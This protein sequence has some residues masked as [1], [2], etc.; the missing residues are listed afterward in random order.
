MARVPR[1]T[2][3]VLLNRSNAGNIAAAAAA[4]GGNEARG[5]R[6]EAQQ[7]R[8]TAAQIDS[9]ARQ[10][11]QQLKAEGRV[12]AQERFNQ[13]E[14]KKI[15]L[16]ST[17]QLERQDNPDGFAKEFDQW[18][19]DQLAEF[20]TSLGND[21]VDEA[22]DLEY[23]RQLMD[24]S[25]TSTLRSNKD[26]EN[27]LRLK[28]TFNNAERNID[29]MNVNFLMSNPSFKDFVDH[30]NKIRDY[31][32]EVGSG[33]FGE[34]DQIRLT[35]FGI[36]NAAKNFLNEKLQSDPKSL[37][38]IM[39]YGTGGKENLIKFTIDEIERGFR[40]HKDND[41][42][43]TRFGINTK[44]HPDF[45]LQSGREGA[46]KYYAERIWDSRLDDM[47]PAF[48]A[49]AF[50]AIVNHGND[51]D[52]WKMIKE[53][54]GNP[55]ALIGL[56][57][58]KYAGLVASGDPRFVNQKEGWQNRLETLTTFVST[59]EGGGNEFIQNASLI[60]SDILLQAKSKLPDALAD[61]A[62][63]EADALKR[64]NN[65]DIFTQIENEKELTSSI[66]DTKIPL[67]ERIRAV[68]EADF[69][70]TV[71]DDFASEAIAYLKTFDSESTKRVP[72]E[73]KL[74]VFNE[75]TE[76]LQQ[77]RIDLGGTFD[78]S[79]EIRVDG[80][81]LGA[82]QDFQKNVL[83]ALKNG[84]I[85]EAE[86]KNFTGD[87]S[88]QI[89]AAIQ[90]NLSNPTDFRIFRGVQDPYGVALQRIDQFLKNTN[91]KG[92][93]RMKKALI[94]GFQEHLGD[95]TS[96]G[97]TAQDE[98][99]ID[100][101][102]ANARKSMNSKNFSGVIDTQNPPNKVV[103]NVPSVDPK[104]IFSTVEEMEAAG[105]PDGTPVIVGGQKGYARD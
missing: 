73:K 85:T 14:R 92:N 28:N 6:Q 43:L 70:G 88:D 98:R 34:E 2:R 82:F 60:D 89:T 8:N 11:N 48:Q 71:R 47:Q 51:E 15:D 96:S 46:E 105:L 83:T 93:L 7:A 95:Y 50:D 91:Q 45:D 76:Q 32:N 94:F 79:G 41:G 65:V 66:Y 31:A 18:H 56:R 40:T 29:D 12:K 20:E 99:R 25:R 62:R 19:Q 80:K 39:E 81:T 13:F 23:Y 75:L 33:I 90:G 67:N 69:R 16:L 57:Q 37:Q 101:A 87:F 17:S 22:F 52:T 49:V 74:V 42:G 3:T 72:N 30:Q 77:I 64:Q 9:F 86:A 78:D 59:L 21:G 36:D 100:A 102:L 35:E 53:A 4:E 54:N 68:R 10:R 26:W 58:K 24:K 97:D 27:G 103:R 5:L 1:F 61:Q 104:H 63:A 84:E 38:Y 55:Q 44:H